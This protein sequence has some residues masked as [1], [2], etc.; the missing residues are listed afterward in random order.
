MTDYHPIDCRLHDHI[1]IACLHRYRLRLRLQG[2]RILTGV[3]TDTETTTEKAEYLWL[4]TAAGAD[5]VRLD[6]IV[7]LEPLEEGAVFGAVR[8]R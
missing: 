5:R 3:A 7:Q 6:E 2:G 1:E 8:F 4:D